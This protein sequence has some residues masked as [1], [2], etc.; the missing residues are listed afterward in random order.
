MPLSEKQPYGQIDAS[1]HQTALDLLGEVADYLGRLP[2]HP[3]THALL[4]RVHS[5]VKNPAAKAQNIR[6]AM[7][8]DSEVFAAK[9]MSGIGFHGASRYTP[10]GLPVIAARLVYPVLRLE[11]PAVQSF[12]SCGDHARAESL[13]TV[14][15]RE[16]LSGVSLDL[17][18]L[19]PVLDRVWADKKSVHVER[20]AGG[21]A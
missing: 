21:D 14:I 9:I 19:H 7:L 2:T 6:L 20:Q 11:S 4:Q 1:Q 5:H 3:M 12:L 13:S 10:I 16:I 8:S 15:G 18:P 17:S